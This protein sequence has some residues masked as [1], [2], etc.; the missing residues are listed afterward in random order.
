[1]TQ[2]ARLPLVHA[3]GEGC[4]PHPMLAE[5]TRT[6]LAPAGRSR[7]I[8]ANARGQIRVGAISDAGRLA[9]RTHNGDALRVVV[10][11]ALATQPPNASMADLAGWATGEFLPSRIDRGRL[12]GRSDRSAV[13][14]RQ[15]RCPPSLGGDPSGLRGRR[16]RRGGSER[17]APSGSVGPRSRGDLAE[18]GRLLERGEQLAALGNVVAQGLIALGRAVSAQLSGDPEAAIA[19][20]DHIPPGSL[21]GEWAAQALMIRGTNTLLSG[22]GP[23]AI[24]ALDAATGEG[25]DAYHAVA[26]DLLATARWYS[27][28]QIGALRDAQTAEDLALQSGTPTF[29]QMVRAAPACLLAATGLAIPPPACSTSSTTAPSAPPPRKRRP[30]AGWPRCCCWP[31]HP[32][33]ARPAMLPST[34]SAQ[35][36]LRS[37]L[38]KTSLSLALLDRLPDEVASLA[39]H[40]TAMGLAVAAGREAAGHLAGGAKVDPRHVPFL[41]PDGAGRPEGR[42]CWPSLGPAG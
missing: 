15:R 16:R 29:L 21:V 39:T 18:L 11:A 28:D 2:L 5:R 32:T 22:R 40:N 27:G 9:L 41:R 36:S 17:P 25:S 20:L 30:W 37:S 31:T 13:G 38:W 19:A 24:A 35:R 7:A 12:V 14:R 10:R 4:W 42:W 26:H 8:V 33:W 3:R 6:V 23:A 34:R 1:M